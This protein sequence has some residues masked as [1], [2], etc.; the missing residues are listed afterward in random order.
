MGTGLCVERTKLNH[1]DFTPIN[2]IWEVGDILEFR[3][4]NMEID[5]SYI[6]DDGMV[7]VRLI[8]TSETIYPLR[9]CDVTVDLYRFFIP[10]LTY[11]ENS[12]TIRQIVNTVL[13]VDI[14]V[15][16]IST[17][18]SNDFLIIRIFPST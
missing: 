11:L 13:A 15:E 18:M 7:P 17:L 6:E 8:P 10:K 9:C 12:K 4:I 2:K 5:N 16:L 1:N 14:I 3:H